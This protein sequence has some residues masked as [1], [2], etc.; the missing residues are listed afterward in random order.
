MSGDKIR[1]KAAAIRKQFIR[2]HHTY[3]GIVLKSYR[4]T[5]EAE[6]AQLEKLIEAH[7]KT[8]LDRFDQDEK[9]SIEELV[10]AF[11][12][13]IVRSPPEDLAD[14]IG[15]RKPTTQE[16]KDYLRHI[17]VAAFPTAVEVA[18][19]MRISRIVKDVSWNTLNEPG[20]VDWL[21][22]QFPHRKDLQQP[23][24]LYH[25][26]REKLKSKQLKT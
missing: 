6:I 23:F 19:G 25:A 21:K 2:H 15:G 7:K 24:E 18:E 11:W 13:D 16:A 1:E 20:F 9:K 8:V 3:G 5:L 26:A 22:N 4:A 10:K 14:Q 17:L 12:R